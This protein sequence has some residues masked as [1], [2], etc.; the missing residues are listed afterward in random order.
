MKRVGLGG[1]VLLVLV[2]TIVMV[3]DRKP[4]YRLV[5]SD[6]FDGDQLDLDNWDYRYGGWDAHNVQGCYTDSPD[7]VSVSN[8]TLTLTATYDEDISCRGG[9]QQGFATGF[10]ES[11]NKQTFT[12][13]YIEAR[14]RVD[15]HNNSLWPAFWL[16]P[17]DAQYGPWPHSGEIDVVEMRTD[18]SQFASADAHWVGPDDRKRNDPE[19][20]PITSTVADWHTYA[21]KWEPGQLDFYLDGEHFHTITEFGA[22][23]F[24]QPFFLRLNLAVGGDFIDSPYRDAHLSINDFPAAMDVD[25]VRVYQRTN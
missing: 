25:Y 10:I 4:D 13:G 17:N 16:S 23:P 1:T 3:Q 8:G 11:K 7:N 22:A 5:W 15:T 24:D 12:Y 6:E 18:N 9:K 2:I 19:L 14:I 21:V 20:A